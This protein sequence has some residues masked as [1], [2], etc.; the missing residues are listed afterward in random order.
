MIFARWVFRVA[1][2][3]GLLVL[4]PQYGMRVVLE[5]VTSVEELQ[6]VAK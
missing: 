2:I 4:L 5:G 6:R 1:G 3:Y